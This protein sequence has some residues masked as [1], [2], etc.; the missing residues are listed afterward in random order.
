M[1]KTQRRAFAFLVAIAI[2]LTLGCARQSGTD[3]PPETAGPGAAQT[4]PGADA[5]A[6]GADAAAPGGAQP[7]TLNAAHILVMHKDSER[8]SPEITRTKEKALA[9]AEEVAEKLKADD[10]DFAALAE[11]YSDC[12][13]KEDGGNLGDFEPDWMAPAF[14]EATQKLAVGETSDIVETAFGYHIIYRYK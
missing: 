1:D 10:A 8:V 4:A 7:T 6:P 9:R 5:A 3:T 14:T 11:E 2:A 12:P 13:S